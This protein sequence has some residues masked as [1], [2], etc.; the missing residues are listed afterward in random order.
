MKAHRIITL[1]IA[2]AISCTPSDGSGSAET[3]QVTIPP[4]ATLAAAAESLFVRDLI[5]SPSLFR[6]YATLT[7]RE[8]AIQAATYDVPRGSSMREILS[9]L[10]SGR[11]AEERLV[12][13][14]GLTLAEVADTIRLQL[15]LSAD[16]L[17]AALTDSARR[18]ELD[19]PGPNLEGYL[20]PSTHLVPIGASARDVV[21]QLTAEFERQWQPDWG[22]RLDSL[23][24]TRHEIVILASIIEGEVRYDPDRPYVSSVYHNRLHRGMRL[25]ADPTVVYAL[26]QRRRLYENDYQVSSPYNTYLISGLPPGPIGQ[27]STASMRAALY[28]T[29]SD[30][31]YFVARPD[32]QH[33]F[34]ET[35][36]E[37][38]RAIR[39]IR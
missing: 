23:G 29:T 35:Y 7:G 28:P 3:V 14:E 33:V 5:S 39:E 16:S 15:G 17:E 18:V 2:L 9:I 36:A 6:F 22:P 21:L 24:M 31:L 25:Q 38:L 32:G 26:G 30:F 13:L 27:P 19:I 1:T 8:R 11:P 12:V 4:G 20:Y 10:V 37:H 34:S